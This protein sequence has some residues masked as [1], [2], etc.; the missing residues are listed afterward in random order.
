MHLKGMR[1]LPRRDMIDRLLKV[2]SVPHLKDMVNHRITDSTTTNTATSIMTNTGINTTTNT[3]INM[4]TEDLHLRFTINRVLRNILLR[5]KDT[6]NR[7]TD[8]LDINNHMV[9]HSSTDSPHPHTDNS[10][11]ENLRIVEVLLIHYEERRY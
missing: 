6:V 5:L 9:G 2:T 3:R 8:N 11:M 1:G 10:I 4:H 7:S